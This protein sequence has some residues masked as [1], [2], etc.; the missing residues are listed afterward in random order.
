MSLFSLLDRFRK[1]GD[2]ATAP[3]AEA[4]RR[5]Q[6][7]VEIG[8]D[9]LVGEAN[10][11]FLQVLGQSAFDVRGHAFESLFEAGGTDRGAWRA[12]WDQASRGGSCAAL[13]CLRGVGAEPVWMQASLTGLAGPGGRTRSVVV[14]ATDVT[15]L[16]AERDRL[17][18]DLKVRSDI[19]NMTSIV[20]EANKKG[21]IIALNDKYTE[22]SQYSRDELLGSP[23]NIT[24]HPDMPKE[25]FKEMWNTIG[26]GKMFRGVVKNRAKDGSP[27]YVD[28]VIAPILGK[29]GK[30]ERYIG[31]RYDITAAETERQNMRGV[32]GAIDESFA[33]VEFTTTGEV[34][35]AN[36]RF[37]KLTGYRADEIT[38]RHH[39]LFM[40]PA[41]AATPDYAQ[42][43]AELGQGHAKADVYR[44]R[45]KE[46]RDVWLQAAYAP[47]RDETGRVIKVVKIATEPAQLQVNEQVR[48]T[49]AEA[50][51]VIA[52]AAAGDLTRRLSAEGRTGTVATLIE[53]INELLGVMSGL[54]SQVK[55]SASEVYRGADE[56]SQG[57]TDLSQRTEQQASS[58]EETASS[59]E[60]MTSIVKQNADNAAQ[61]NLLAHAA[62]DQAENGGAVVSKA[63]RAMAGIDES[64]KR[65]AD[66][67]GVIDEIAFQTNLLALNAAVE[68]ARA[69]EQGRGF[70][71]VAT[72]VRNL[73]GRSASAA[74]EIKGLIR[75]SVQKVSE[76][77][78]LVTQSGA[79]LDGIVTSV[80][81]VADIVA[82]IAAAS[83]EQHS[84]IE[85]VNKAVMQLD[86][87]TQQ[88]AALVEEAS[89]ASRS[90][91]DQARSLNDMVNSYRVDLPVE[92]ECD[93]RP[94]LVASRR[95]P[96]RPR[97]TKTPP[98]LR[99]V[100]VKAKVEDSVWKE[101]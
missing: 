33:Y 100:N 58:L 48:L 31:V 64:S 12:A 95:E 59:M 94:V 4:V 17:A 73:A 24:R 47:V 27:Y 78:E 29:N 28:A 75:D 1:P 37:L 81:K 35:R 8:L 57:N 44:R 38:G 54:I 69:G 62:R 60:Q 10:D 39:R 7:V 53:G 6:A 66:I 16:H 22:V 99:S 70:A 43:W 51:E 80:K 2:L 25:V 71:V 50:S 85:Q 68:A 55:G 76:G 20:S 18:A 89:A 40:D 13:L 86:E 96:A 49:V 97:V 26:H 56:I 23:H 19:L 93:S 90:M 63:V 65:I 3:L 41:E 9:G 14:L 11:V 61:A 101:F 5:T 46:G 88:N 74:K 52:A 36:D 34:L 83:Q 87:L 21:E 15:A 92:D 91:A 84:G 79:T 72:E 32:L 30:P 82:E 45:S 67:I 77:S 98:T 42:F